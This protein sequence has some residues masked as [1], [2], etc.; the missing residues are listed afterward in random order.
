LNEAIEEVAA[1]VARDAQFAGISVDYQLTPDLRPVSAD[2][3]QLQQIVLNLLVNSRQAMTEAA[4]ATKQI[5]V[6]TYRID[7]DLLGVAVDDTGP[8][9]EALDTDAAF[10]AF[11][12]TK[13]GGLGLGLAI[14]RMIAEAHGGT[15]QAVGKEGPGARFELRLP[16]GGHR[17]E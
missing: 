2:R 15:L 11:L 16:A 12:T 1:M 4:S 14:S 6:E 5:R 8:G 7:E 10:D 13:P 17:L 9:T 3:V